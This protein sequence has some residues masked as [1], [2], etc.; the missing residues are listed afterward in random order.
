VVGWSDSAKSGDFGRT[1]ISA[2]HIS[3]AVV[4]LTAGE[5][6]MRK[7][8]SRVSVEAATYLIL[9]VSKFDLDQGWKA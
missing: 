1:P 6:I 3:Y 2:I 4:G 5:I 7:T 8:V 9:T